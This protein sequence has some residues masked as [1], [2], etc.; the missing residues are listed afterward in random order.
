[1]NKRNNGWTNYVL[2]S[3]LGNRPTYV[4]EGEMHIKERKIWQIILPAK[5]KIQYA[6]CM[7]IFSFRIFFFDFL[8]LFFY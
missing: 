2:G 8:N 6:I 7:L 1:M 3:R 5:S 4:I